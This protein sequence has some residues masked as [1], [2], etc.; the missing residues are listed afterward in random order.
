MMRITGNMFENSDFYSDEMRESA[1]RAFKLASDIAELKD[2]L[3]GIREE[4]EKLR[5]LFLSED[6]K[7]ENQ[8]Q[9]RNFDNRMQNMM[10][11]TFHNLEQYQM[12]G[13]KE[14]FDSE[15]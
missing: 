4:S 6:E 10:C 11:T 8:L 15:E 12:Q 5:K 3:S 2:L 13:W 14:L 9:V 1:A 7:A